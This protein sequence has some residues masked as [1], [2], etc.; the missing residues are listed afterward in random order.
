MAGLIWPSWPD[1]SFSTG[2]G[3]TV[4]GSMAGG[5][6]GGRAPYNISASRSAMDFIPGTVGGE[7]V[8][9]RCGGG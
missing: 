7:K 5:G 8:C 4:G 6:P 9:G 3:V 2:V 1:L